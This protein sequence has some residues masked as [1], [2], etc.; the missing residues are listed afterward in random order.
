MNV[1]PSSGCLHAKN[2]TKKVTYYGLGTWVPYLNN[3][4][5]VRDIQN[6]GF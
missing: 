6:E 2:L 3:H 5:S 4:G 1:V